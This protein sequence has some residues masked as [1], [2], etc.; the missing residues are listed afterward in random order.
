MSGLRTIIIIDDDDAVRD[1][2]S[3]LLEAHG[4]SIQTFVSG[5][6][7]LQ[8]GHSHGDCIL[9]DVRMP[10]RDG[11][12]TLKEFRASGC[13]I[14]VI[15]MSGHADVAMAVTALKSGAIDFVEKPFDAGE[16]LSA[17]G[18]ALAERTAY[19]DAQNARLEAERNFARL[20]PRE[21]EIA[22]LL[23]SGEPNKG[24]ARAL[25]I[26]VRTVETHRA[27]ILSKLDIRSLSDLV[28]LMMDVAPS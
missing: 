22:S 6:A 20:T 17:I 5:D 2:L 23:V 15:V 16:L 21:K 26:S 10:G 13:N 28:R 4:F 19:L 25:D 3:I 1:S 7:F 9:M 18:R 27:N 8:A 12:T 24:V 14:P 11:L